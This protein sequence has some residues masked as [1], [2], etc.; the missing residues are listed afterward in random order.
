MVRT[1]NLDV[2]VDAALV[3]D[4]PTGGGPQ[5]VGAM[6]EAVAL[7]ADLGLLRLQHRLVGGA[8]CVVTI[9]AILAHRRVLPQERTALLGMA[10]V[11]IVVDRGFAD[12]RLGARH[13]AVR[14]V[15]VRAGQL[16]LAHRHVR[17][18]DKAAHAGPYGTGSRLPPRPAPRVGS[19]A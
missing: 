12:H 16:A 9:Q 3:E 8:M 5:Q 17:R 13:A 1:M 10:L 19:W 18:R 15:A 4:E 2:A 6:V 11:A 14:I 7:A